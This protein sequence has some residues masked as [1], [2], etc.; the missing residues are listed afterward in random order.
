MANEA[1]VETFDI[2][3]RNVAA[4]LLRTNENATI[5]ALAV[6]RHCYRRQ[7]RNG[8]SDESFMLF[9][10]KTLDELRTAGMRFGKHRQR[11]VPKPHGE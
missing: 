8:S 11:K 3:T 2:D 4:K 10:E 6:A 9:I 5:Y 7:Y 1:P